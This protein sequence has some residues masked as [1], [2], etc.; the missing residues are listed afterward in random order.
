MKYYINHTGNQLSEK[1]MISK[2]KSLDKVYI[3]NN[4]CETIHSNISKYIDENK[5]S[6]N[7]FRI[8]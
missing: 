5:I 1:N 2:L 3:I 4:I 6:K 7:T 8:P